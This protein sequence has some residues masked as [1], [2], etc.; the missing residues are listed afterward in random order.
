MNDI[1]V[2]A[3]P[4]GSWEHAVDERDLTVE[5]WKELIYKVA[6]IAM[7][8]IIWILILKSSKKKSEFEHLI[9][10][11][12]DY[13]LTHIIIIIN[14]LTIII[15]INILVIIIIIINIQTI[16][17]IIQEVV[18]YELTHNTHTDGSPRIPCLQVSICICIC[19]CICHSNHTD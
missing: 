17:T 15:V 11:V 7:L 14:N 13:K 1:Q 5:Q 3:P 9:Q 18:D 6:A 12:V 16:I 19:I 2:N 4:P 8:E 10:E